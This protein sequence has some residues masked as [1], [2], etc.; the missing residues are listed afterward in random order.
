MVCLNYNLFTFIKPYIELHLEMVSKAIL[1]LFAIL[2]NN[3]NKIYIKS[4]NLIRVNF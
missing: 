2:R 3:L 4:E 1:E